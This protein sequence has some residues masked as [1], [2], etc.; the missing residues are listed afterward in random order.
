MTVDT[1]L[2]TADELLRMPDDGFRYE[3]VRGELRKTSPAGGQ[4]GRIA[5]RILIRLGSHVEQHALGVTYSSETGF[6]LGR[7]PDSVRAPDVA[8]VSRERVVDVTGYIPGP[9]DLAVEVVSPNDSYSEVREKTREWLRA[10]TRA[11][12]VV[13]GAKHL[14]ELHRRDRID[15]VE[16][17]LEIEDIV[18]GWKLPV[19]Q[20]FE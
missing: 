8:F 11:V 4:H 14:V 6:I 16:D 19:T 12:V 3:L 10:G 13:D 7:N 17:V 20:I 5:A 15:V 1:R 9:P 2:H 18:P